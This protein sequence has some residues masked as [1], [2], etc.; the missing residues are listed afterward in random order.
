MLNECPIS[1]ERKTRNICFSKT[2][3]GF[4]WMSCKHQTVHEE[5]KNTHTHNFHFENLILTMLFYIS[6]LFYAFADCTQYSILFI[7][8][9]H[10]QAFQLNI[11]AAVCNNNN[12]NRVFLFQSFPP[13]SKCEWRFFS[14]LLMTY[15][16]VHFITSKLIEIKSEAN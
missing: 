1:S 9:C 13:N 7:Y 11:L 5:K 16:E 15:T 8:W 2:I 10:L 14:A 12:K 6:L 4:T 3:D